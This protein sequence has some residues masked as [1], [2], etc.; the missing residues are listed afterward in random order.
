MATTETLTL[1][2]G[3]EA[4]RRIRVAFVASR[5]PTYSRVAIVREALN[6][7]FDVIAFVSTSKRYWFRIVSVLLQFIAARIRGQLR[8][9]DVLVVGFFAQPILPVLRFLW[10]GPVI[11]DGY[12]SI[13]DT[14]VN[15]KAKA[16][17]NSILGRLC[18]GLDRYMLRKADLVMT[19]TLEHVRYFQQTFSVTNTTLERLWISAQDTVFTR[20]AALPLRDGETCEILFWGGFVPLQ[21]VDA[22]IRAAHRLSGQPV[23]FTIVGAGQ[24]YQACSDLADNLATENVAFLGW[25]TPEEIRE[26][27]NRS[28]LILGIFGTTDK[29][30]RVIPNKAF[31]ALALGKP[32]ITGDSP[33]SRELLQDG[34]DAMLVPLGDFEA[35]AERITWARENYDAALAIGSCGH[36]TFMDKASPACI[37]DLLAGYVQTQVRTAMRRTATSTS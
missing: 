21:G 33:A 36:S 3:R 10:R 20:Q 5:E 32:L 26:I 27:A 24:T 31:E 22:I 23:H 8:D 9:V 15:D 2:T 29:A 11:A 18:Y 1:A 13:Y 12:F 37:S 4:S 17:P 14:L 30:A 7:R 16:G 35:L 34:H 28:H 25:Q 6:E 19:D